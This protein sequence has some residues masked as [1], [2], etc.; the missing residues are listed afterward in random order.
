MKNVFMLEK[1]LKSKWDMKRF[2]YKKN[3]VFFI[4]SNLSDTGFVRGDR[5]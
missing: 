2:F 1:C 3:R 4:F 5:W